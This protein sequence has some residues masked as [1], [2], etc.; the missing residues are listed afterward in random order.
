MW[1]IKGQK[2][3]GGK[4]ITKFLGSSDDFYTKSIRWM[5]KEMFW[6]GGLDR[7]K[8]IPHDVECFLLNNIIRLTIPIPIPGLFSLSYSA[9]F[10][11]P[12]YTLLP[13]YTHENISRNISSEASAY[14]SEQ[15]VFWIM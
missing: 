1:S 11:R 3:R 15:H 7:K 14:I 5:E 13:S 9:V 12:I 6:C 10:Y 4:G 2:K 8:E